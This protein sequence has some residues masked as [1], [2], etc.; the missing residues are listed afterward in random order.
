MLLGP[1]QRKATAATLFIV[2]FTNIFGP[3]VCLA[4]TSGPT[5]PEAT[6][7]E[8]VDTTDMVNM[9]TGDFTYNIPLIEV[10]GPE[11]GY[12]LSL[13]YHAG[14]QTN[15]D[16]SWVGLGWTLNPGAINRSVNGYPDDMPGVKT[17]NRVYWSGTTTT[18]Y[19][20]GLSVG[21]A[22]TPAN[23]NF[24]LSFSQDTYRGFGQGYSIG[25]GGGFKLGGS[26]GLSAGLNY[27]VNPYGGNYLSGNL[28]LSYGSGVNG[29][30]GVGFSTN[31]SSLE[32][33]FQAGVGY[34]FK[35]PDSHWSPIGGS[36]IGATIGSGG[37]KPSLEVGGLTASVNNSNAGIVST[38]SHSLHADIPVYFGIN[39]SL[40]YSKVRSW[41]SENVNVT[42]YGCL[43]SNGL[44]TQ[45]TAGPDNIAYDE[46]SLLEDPTYKNF[47]DYPDPTTVQGG[48]FP[49]FDSYSVNA[50]GL[51]GN[52]RPY[53]FQGVILNQNIKGGSGGTTPYV[54]YYSDLP[55]N[56]PLFFRFENDFSNSYRQQEQPYSDPSLNLRT[57]VVPMD[58]SPIYGNNDGT[59]GFGGGNKLAGSKHVDIGPLIHP[60]SALGYL[61]T[62]RFLSGMIEGYSITNESG[63]TYHFGLPAYSYG[64]ENYQEKI[65]RSNGLYFNRVTKSTPY[66]Y[67]WYLTSIT[68]P[69]FVDRNGNGIADDGD[70][71][72]WV[73]FQ[74][75]KWSNSYNWRNPS[76][77]YQR[78]PDNQWQDCSIGSKEVYYLNAIRT[79]SH[80][81]LFEKGIRYDAKG[82]SPASFNKNVDAATQTKT[83]YTTWGSYDINSS[84][85]LKLTH[86]YLLNA[87][88]ENFVTPTSGNSSAYKPSGS[89]TIFCSDCELAANILDSTDVEA[90]GRTAL[91]AK[92]IRVVD[93]NYDYSLC[94]A[95]TNSFDINNAAGLYG[96]LTLNS[97]NTRGKG[98]VG[99]IPPV[100]FKY[101]LTGADANVQTGVTMNS[102]NFSTTNNNFNVGDMVMTSGPPVI[103]CGII[104]AKSLPSG[105]VYTYT[106]ANSKF[107][108]STS[109]ATIY[110]T[111]NP[112]Y[113][114][115]AYDS[116]GSYKGDYNSTT[117]LNNENLGRTTS[118]ASSRAADAWSLRCINTQLGGQL[119]I[120][121]ES[122]S[123]SSSVLSDGYP[124]V[125]TDIEP[126]TGLPNQLSIT[127]AD[128]NGLN[129][130]DY[131]SPTG[132][133]NF[134]MLLR[135]VDP[136]SVV[137]GAYPFCG[138]W[139][140]LLF[141]DQVYNTKQ[142]ANATTVVSVNTSTNT[143]T[144][145]N[146]DF[147]TFYLK[148]VPVVDINGQ[149][150]TTRCIQSMIP[151]ACNIKVYGQT[152]VLG[153]GVRV[154][155][156]DA[157]EPQSNAIS[158][159]IY[160]YDVAGSPGVSSGTT[161]FEPWVLET[162]NITLP[163]SNDL[164][165]LKLYK[166]SL[167]SNMNSLLAI[168]REVPPPNVMYQYVTVS[169]QVK[170]PDELNPRLVPGSTQYQFE[171]FRGNMVSRIDETP[172]TGPIVNSGGFGTMFTRNVAITKFTNSIGNVKRIIQFDQ[173][174]QK[175]TETINH[176]LHDGLE[177]LDATYFIPQYQG[178]LGV[179]YA[180][181]GFLQERYSEVKEVQNQAIGADN[182]VKA[183]LSAKEQYPCIQTGQTVI[184]Y[185][186]GTQTTSTNLKYDFYSGA[187]TQSVTTDSYGNNFMTE[188]VPAYRK[189]G[190]MGMKIGAANNKNMLTQSAGSYVWKVDWNNAK[191]ELSSANVTTWSDSY[192]AIDIDGTPYVQNSAYANGDVWRPQSSYAYL[193]T[194]QTSDG[195]TPIGNFVDFNFVSPGSS[196]P[197][198][199]TTSTATLYDVYSKPLEAKDID[200]NYSAT[201][202]NY[203][204]SRVVLT[205]S[206]ANFYEIAYSGAEDA[207]INQL[208]NNFVKAVDGV[209]TSGAGVAHTGT[210]SLLLGVSG[211][212]GF[213][214]SVSTNNLV[215]GRNYQA[216]V[217]VKPVSG[218]VSDVKLYYDINGTIKANSISSG[219]SL[220][221]ANGWYLINLP[222]SGADIVAGN[223]LNIWCRNDHVSVQSYVDDMRFQPVN[224]NTV[225]YVY[226]QSSGELTY[227]LNNSN[228][229][230]NYV[231]D[232]M[233]RLSA[234][235]KEKLGYGA[236]QVKGYQYNYNTYASAAISQNY[237]VATCLQGD[238]PS[239][240]LI[241]VPAGAFSSTVSQP[242]ADAQAQAYAQAQA[243]MQGTC[244][245]PVA[246]NVSNGASIAVVFKV[247]TTTVRSATFGVGTGSMT[248]P[249]GT[250]DIEVIQTDHVSHNVTLSSA[251][252]TSGTDVTFTNISLQ[253]PVTITVN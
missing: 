210:K 79:R 84:Q 94:A 35:A 173:Y 71:G 158:S 199:K 9:Q 13:S 82:T 225:A 47:V 245:V 188:T 1:A 147:A 151:V 177:N 109:S 98:G 83:D 6:S 51:S 22:G 180:W 169:N 63:V 86:I 166:K 206:P 39:L 7:F 234:V 73:D 120:N 48:S 119:K 139:A 224:S 115:D 38:S 237:T 116:W 193:P 233:G 46:Y 164:N 228:I 99:L 20:A 29:S 198:W 8:P 170:N 17:S 58:G 143:I 220:K 211:K 175:I 123:Y 190:A 34:S 36:I 159:T 213:L 243:N 160:N 85:N 90:A 149:R 205:G 217:W 191:Q 129:L 97:V 134:W 218:S 67:T 181:Q 215:A 108:G 64:E 43:N 3:S 183:I 248:V 45:Y 106:L 242:D 246:V 95:T 229:Y 185:V 182:G 212:K 92:A 239:T 57:A 194:T 162:I 37:T 202:M 171:V 25:L 124:F 241:S 195:M 40:G 197:S 214:Y 33:G 203:G 93:F 125:A 53:Q 216:S 178:K 250:Y 52:I 200:N 68:G 23:V 174:G 117:I 81:A 144:V 50:Q 69:D 153:G 75:G 186:N 238:I 131:F 66:A 232:A 157:I 236:F 103:Y 226:D 10:P 80:V 26:F 42:T 62:D 89:R 150:I 140:S 148:D 204:D 44:V 14:I 209:V 105:G 2:L 156:L 78:D 163:N 165:G 91:E 96:K 41:T 107:V 15:E 251:Y 88:D 145:Q 100:T 24:N 231:Y 28:S 11:G 222:I 184:N 168:S 176:Y 179:Y 201:R 154:H 87:S 249:V 19:S 161:S 128:V 113:F 77:K 172:R 27:G 5:Q 208:G 102:Q 235:Y 54:T 221:S 56:N 74:Y 101:D 247:G 187:V 65:D 55:T 70:W 127:L 137:I 76:E 32:T 230:T 49:D 253:T 114:R 126:V 227:V 132:T 110:K 192:Q 152:V 30:V 141:T 240:V 219:S 61:K 112:P 252:G 31:F 122:D 18:T 223:T 196:D 135:C 207:G 121:Y 189:Y 130:N 142:S 104:T 12:P 60:R 21:L 155:E 244:S 4:L 59:F 167:Y 111:K 133:V 146:P 136:N 72:Y 16:A 138:G 118:V